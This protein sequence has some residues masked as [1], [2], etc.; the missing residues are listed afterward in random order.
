MQD[1]RTERVFNISTGELEELK[2]G[3]KVSTQGYAQA[4]GMSVSSRITGNMETASMKPSHYHDAPFDVIKAQGY[5]MGNFL[6]KLQGR[7]MKGS[8]WASS[9]AWAVGAAVKHL[10]R[11]GL[12]DDVDIELAKAE[13]YLHFA[14]TGEFLND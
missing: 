7:E 13:N 5:I 3:D 4:A 14:R 10:C 2:K 12:K 6:G 9:R 11:L 8:A 1:D